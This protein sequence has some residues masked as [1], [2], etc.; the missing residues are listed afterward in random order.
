MRRFL[1]FAL[2]V[3]GGAAIVGGSTVAWQS[4]ASDLPRKRITDRLHDLEP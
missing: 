2:A 4:A 3:P 1:V